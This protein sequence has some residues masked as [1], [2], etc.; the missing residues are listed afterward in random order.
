MDSERAA[1]QFQE[2][3][4]AGSMFRNLELARCVHAQ[5]PGHRGPRPPPGGPSGLDAARARERARPRVRADAPV[6]RSPGRGRSLRRATSA[7]PVQCGRGIPDPRS[8]LRLPGAP[9]GRDPRHSGRV[10]GTTAERSADLQRSTPA[11]LARTRRTLRGLALEPLHPAA[12]R[13]A[14]HNPQTAELLALLDALR[15]GRAGGARVR[16]VATDELRRRLTPGPA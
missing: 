14:A 8:A 1:S 9:P 13:A 5:R 2:Q 7:G 16:G 3:S 11:D 12:L 6:A 15:A 10:G 4:W